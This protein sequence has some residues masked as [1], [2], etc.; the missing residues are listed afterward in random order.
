MSVLLS[1]VCNIL[2]IALVKM[3]QRDRSDFFLAL[4][5][6]EVSKYVQTRGRNRTDSQLSCVHDDDVACGK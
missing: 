2:L 5:N 4:T 1:T 3:S 6:K